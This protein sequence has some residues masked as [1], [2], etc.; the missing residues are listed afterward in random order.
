MRDFSARYDPGGRRISVS[1]DGQ[2]CFV[3]CYYE[4]G[5]AAYSAMDGTELWRRRDLKAVQRVSAFP[6]EDLV[7]CGRKDSGHLLCGGSGRTIER[8]RGIKAVYTSPFSRHVL[9]SA[10]ALEVHSA[11]GTKIGKIERTT[12]AELDCCF[13]DSEI[14]VTESGG[15][16]RCFDL[17]SLAL[18]WTHAPKAGSHFL[19]L[20]F[21][22][23]LRCFVGVRWNYNDSRD[24]VKRLVH[25]ERRAG[26]VLRDVPIGSPTDHGF[27]LAGSAVFTSDLQLISVE[28]GKIMHEFRQPENGSHA[29]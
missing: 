7:F 1:R 18:L 27:C 21:S 2:S 8:S 5:M 15:S 26:T 12:F 14:L 23:A 20:C 3:G 19:R 11:F 6:F 9:A 25:F 29:T 28:T 24:P 10:H 4:Y 17:G 13:S 22:Q 16:L